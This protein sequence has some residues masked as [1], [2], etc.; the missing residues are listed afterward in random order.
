MIVNAPTA[1]TVLALL[2]ILP[3]RLT[4]LV[5]M[6]AV[7]AYPLNIAIYHVLFCHARPLTITCYSPFGSSYSPTALRPWGLI[8]QIYF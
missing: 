8:A 3:L 1:G 5:E 2:G 6:L 7:G 4:V